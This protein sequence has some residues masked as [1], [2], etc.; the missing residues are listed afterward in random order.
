MKHLALEF[1]VHR[2]LF[3]AAGAVVV[4]VVLSACGPEASAESDEL[5]SS[6]NAV[7]VDPLGMES[8]TA[9]VDGDGVQDYIERDFFNLIS[10]LRDPANLVVM[11]QIDHGG[12]YVPGQ[13][14]F[15]DLNAD[16]RAD[17][18]FRG[19]DNS[20]WVSLSAGSTLKLPAKWM[21]HGGAYDPDQAHYADLNADRRA[22]LIM[23]GLDNS[24]WVSLSTGT[25][26]GSPVKWLKHGGTYTQ[27]QAK[28]SDLNGD[29]KADLTFRGND[30]KYWI[31]YSTGTGFTTPKLR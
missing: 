13:M 16:R 3:S 4:A 21:Q 25:S 30:G 15:A 18:I 31:S 2:N 7:F 5:G 9:D 27:G 20:F 10:V 1:S 11:T 23:R 28:Y 29:R 12:T 26:F 17:L 24:F 8:T 22:D 14:K 6:E 19:T